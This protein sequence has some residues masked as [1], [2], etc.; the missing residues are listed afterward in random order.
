MFQMRALVPHHIIIIAMR[1]PKRVGRFDRWAA[2][3]DVADFRVP[4][5]EVV[6]ALCTG[7]GAAR[8]DVDVIM[9]LGHETVYGIGGD[10]FVV[11]FWVVELATIVT[12]KVELSVGS[13]KQK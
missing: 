10:S 2:P 12:K 4:I 8:G 9:W 3:R 11:M 13:W 6:A 1:N 5:E 7:L